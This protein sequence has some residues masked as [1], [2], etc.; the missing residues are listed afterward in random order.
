MKVLQINT[1]CGIGSTGRIAVDLYNTLLANGHEG[2]IAYGRGK[3]PD[4][5]QT[6][7]IGNKLNTYIHYGLTKLFDM[8]C[9]SSIIAT[10]QLIKKIDEYNPDII[11]LHNIHGYYINTKILFK[12]L[13]KTNK[14]IVWT[15]HDCWTFTGHCA[16]FDYVNCEKWKKQCENCPQKKSYP[17]SLFWDSSKKN[18]NI[19]KRVLTE[20]KKIFFVTPSNWLAELVKK[21]FLK[22]FPVEVINNGIDLQKF[23]PIKNEIKEKYNIKDKFVILGVASA[24]E[25]RKGLKYFIELSK[26]L[27]ESFKIVLIGISEEIK[28]DIPENIITIS[29]TNSVEELANFYSMADVFV[30]PTLEDNFPTT[31]LESLACGTPVIT[32]KTGGSPESISE[33]CGVVVEKGNAEKLYE[34]IIKIKKKNVKEEDCIKKSKDYDK[35]NKYKEYIELYMK[36]IEGEQNS[37]KQGK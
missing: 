35:N 2:I 19:K 1:V 36:I 6:I 7:K 33:K 13:K 12:Y 26:K 23:K 34:A 9:R 21:S 8:H 37:E 10:K 3:A 25:T 22:K 18:F 31:N 16:Y 14:P 30:N 27:D 29:R 5:I 28:K 24:W 32:F 15:L 17:G 4:G 20:N 11:H